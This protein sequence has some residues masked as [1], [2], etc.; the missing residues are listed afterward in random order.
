MIEKDKKKKKYWELKKINKY[1]ENVGNFFF[2][3]K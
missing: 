2:L 3:I 1:H